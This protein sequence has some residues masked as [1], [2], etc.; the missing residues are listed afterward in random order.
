MRGLELDPFVCTVP[1]SSTQLNLSNGCSFPR[2]LSASLISI[3]YLVNISGLT[4][5][6]ERIG[7]S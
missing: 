2:E 7:N 1:F 6:E 4:F 3:V 5:H